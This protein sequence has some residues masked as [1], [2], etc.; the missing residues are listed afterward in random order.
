MRSYNVNK[1]V[2]LKPEN[3]ILAVSYVSLGKHV[4]LNKDQIAPVNYEVRQ[5]HC[6][7]ARPIFYSWFHKKSQWLLFTLIKILQREGMF[8]LNCLTLKLLH[9]K[10]ILFYVLYK[11]YSAFLLFYFKFYTILLYNIY[12]YLHLVILKI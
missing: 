12:V 7:N 6:F 3:W 5:I 2:S 4:T 11:F 8:P 10:Q 1:T 9:I